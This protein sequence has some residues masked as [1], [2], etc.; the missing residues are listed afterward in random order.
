MIA[1]EDRLGEIKIRA[2]L[3]TPAPLA[4]GIYDPE[5][6]PVEL[7][8]QNLDAAVDQTES[9]WVVWCPKHP[10]SN[11]DPEGHPTHAVLAA[12]T[13]NGPT[14]EANAEFFANARDDIPWLIY[15]VE[16]LRDACQAAL[17]WA[18]AD[19]WDWQQLAEII[20]PLLSKAITDL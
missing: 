1:M 20:V 3:A 15:K 16:S 13:G 10:D 2:S 5:L 9:V 8:R 7:F 12:I 6:D 18:Q 17:L 4:V 19:D 14:S 11:P